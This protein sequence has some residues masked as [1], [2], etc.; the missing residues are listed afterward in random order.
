MP[1]A[2]KEK[3]P[4]VVKAKTV[5]VSVSAKLAELDLAYTD[6][7]QPKNKRIGKEPVEVTLTPLVV[8]LRRQGYL[9]TEGE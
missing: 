4:E 7:D 8:E 5:I 9:V 6:P 3:A 2:I 1:E